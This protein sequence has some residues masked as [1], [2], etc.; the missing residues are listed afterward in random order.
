MQY[1]LNN[2]FFTNI[3]KILPGYE[4]RAA[5]RTEEGIHIKK[6]ENKRIAEIIRDNNFARNWFIW[7]NAIIM[8]I[9][10]MIPIK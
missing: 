1:N 6:S 7:A 4:W 2:H 8:I 10:N 5:S 9:K 3:Q